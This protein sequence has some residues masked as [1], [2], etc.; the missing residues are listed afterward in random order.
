MPA[1]GSLGNQVPPGPGEVWKQ[2]KDLQ[3]Q[4]QTALSY[5]A[6]AQAVSSQLAANVAALAASGTTWQGPVA[7]PSTVSAATD[8]NATNNV[9][10]GNNVTGPNVFGTSIFAANAGVIAGNITS[11]R[12]TL[13]ARNSDGYIGNTLSSRDF[14]Q[15]IVV[16]DIDPLAVLAI[17]IKHYRYIDEVRRRDD[18]TFP[19]YVGPNY[20]VSLEIGMIAE[21]LHAAGLWQFVAYEHTFSDDGVEKLVLVNGQP[22]PQSI[23]YGLWG[24]AVQVA[25]QHV[26]AEHLKLADRVTAIEAKLSITA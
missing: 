6:S 8:V 3:Q 2:I 15:D 26:W 23:H 13:W 21:D 17:S 20:H 19:D 16:S 25:T 18:P 9:N 4:V 11:S 1:P 7:S 10:A 24:L 12:T 5:A 22:V 14:K